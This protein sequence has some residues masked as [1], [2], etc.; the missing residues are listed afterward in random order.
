MK[1]LRVACFECVEQ[2]A[3]RFC[4]QTTAKGHSELWSEFPVSAFS[5]PILAPLKFSF[6]ACSALCGSPCPSPF[7]PLELF[8]GA[9][10]STESPAD[11]FAKIKLAVTAARPLSETE[12]RAVAAD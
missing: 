6:A 5:R 2:F 7:N 12:T 4:G 10:P 1:I 3:V 8:V 9:S 11:F